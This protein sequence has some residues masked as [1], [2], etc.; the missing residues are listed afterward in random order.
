MRV[1]GRSGSAAARRP[2]NSSRA[3]KPS[4]GDTLELGPFYPAVA[5][6]A[7]GTTPGHAR[8]DIELVE[9]IRGSLAQP[10]A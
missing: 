3:M 7:G 6:R 9:E 2:G 4:S 10:D 1:G 8:R 5:R